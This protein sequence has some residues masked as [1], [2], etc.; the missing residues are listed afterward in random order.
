MSREA[1]SKHPLPYTSRPLG[2]G[3]YSRW[4]LILAFKT[5]AGES[6]PVRDERD[7]ITARLAASDLHKQFPAWQYTTG[8]SPLDGSRRIWVKTTPDNWESFRKTLRGYDHAEQ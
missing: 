5:A 7:M 3:A 6:L 4:R 2:K 1:K 8:T